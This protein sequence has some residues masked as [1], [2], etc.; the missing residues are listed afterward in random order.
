MYH[1]PTTR[2]TTEG[3]EINPAVPKETTTSPKAEDPHQEA[4]TPVDPSILT[5]PPPTDFWGQAP[6]VG[7]VQDGPRFP[8]TGDDAE[9]H[10]KCTTASRT[11][12][13]TLFATQSESGA[14]KSSTSFSIDNDLDFASLCTTRAVNS[15]SAGTADLVDPLCFVNA[16]TDQTTS[17]EAP[18]VDVAQR[19]QR[20]TAASHKTRCSRVKTRE[21]GNIIPPHF[22]PIHRGV[23]GQNS[24]AT[25]IPG[26]MNLVGR[27]NTTAGT[28]LSVRDR[29]GGLFVYDHSG[30]LTHATAAL[31]AFDATVPGVKLTSCAAVASELGIEILCS[32]RMNCE[33]GIRPDSAAEMKETSP[34]RVVHRLTTGHAPSV[35]GRSGGL[36]HG[37]A[38]AGGMVGPTAPEHVVEN[39]GIEQI[40]M[41]PHLMNRMNG[42]DPTAE[43]GFKVGAEKEANLLG[44]PSKR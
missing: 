24:N 11:R 9:V 8:T 2:G 4:C 35:R 6:P 5:I 12:G 19:P 38:A 1:H 34:L 30:E 29:R 33:A 26:P 44:S 31:G 43:V 42:I 36:I 40:G 25:E 28:D 20:P 13:S 3:C 16:S 21:K 22:E 41:S 7:V 10:W 39:P 23:V 27:V 37:A 17:L 32:S 15:R 14:T 18:M